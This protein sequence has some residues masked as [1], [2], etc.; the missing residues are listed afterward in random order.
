MRSLNEMNEAVARAFVMMLKAQKAF[1]PYVN[2]TKYKTNTAT[3]T[4]FL[5][6]HRIGRD[7]NAK[8]KWNGLI[9]NSFAWLDTK[10]CKANPYYWSKL[11]QKWGEIIEKLHKNNYEISEDVSR[12][13]LTS[14]NK[15]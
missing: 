6:L 14:S 12:S 11:H 7:I 2:A 3:F 15:I 9:F 1:V 10:E 5:K 13:I 8:R 4:Y